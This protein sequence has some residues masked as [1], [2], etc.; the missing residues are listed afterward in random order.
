MLTALAVVLIVAVAGVLAVATLIAARKV[1]SAATRRPTCG[2]ETLIGRLGTVREPLAP[3]GQVLVDGSLWRARETWP[4]A[5]AP[6]VAGGDRVVVER[7]DGL[8]LLVR[9]AETWEVE[10]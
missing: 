8:T 1:A 3:L 5:G 7:V 6:A 9:R 2:P 4:D 10:A